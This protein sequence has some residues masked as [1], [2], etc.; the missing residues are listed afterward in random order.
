[1]N[2]S[3]L[4]LCHGRLECSKGTDIAR[5][6]CG[7]AYGLGLLVYSLIISNDEKIGIFRTMPTRHLIDNAGLLA[8]DGMDLCLKLRAVEC[9]G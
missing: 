3:E 2:L 7:E 5:E 4:P 9:K 1:M 8:G 6:S